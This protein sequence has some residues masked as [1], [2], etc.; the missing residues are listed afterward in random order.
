MRIVDNDDVFKELN[1]LC[2]PIMRYL[3][4]HHNIHTEICISEYGIQVKQVIIGIPKEWQPP[5]NIADCTGILGANTDKSLRAL[6]ASV[7][8]ERR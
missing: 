8:A 5:N 6:E 4:T 1:V 2:E 7:L 3:S